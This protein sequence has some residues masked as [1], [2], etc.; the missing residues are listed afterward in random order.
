MSIA[1][2]WRKEYE[3]I[4]SQLKK[5]EETAIKNNTLVGRNFSVSVADGEAYYRCVEEKPRT[6]VLEWVPG[7]LDEYS[8][9]NLGR[10]RSSMSKNKFK[11]MLRLGD[12]GA[13]I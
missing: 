1:D 2:Q 12:Y 6:V 9:W 7:I 4:M 5:E 10:G 3:A 8:D 11:A 13:T